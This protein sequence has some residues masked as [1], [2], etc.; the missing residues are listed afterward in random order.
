[1]SDGVAWKGSR[2]WG[3]GAPPTSSP[4]PPPRALPPLVCAVRRGQ[5]DLTRNVDT[6]KD[7]RDMEKR[8]LEVLKA[9]SS[10]LRMRR[11][12]SRKAPSQPWDLTIF[13]FPMTLL[14]SR[15]RESFRV[16]CSCW[17]RREE[18]G[19]GQRNV[20]NSPSAKPSHPAFS[21]CS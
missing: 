5:G 8:R 18:E 6:W 10:W 7:T 1:M 15:A 11:I 20:K 14:V 19:R 2:I 21:K 4:P 13:I 16:M 17:H 9:P 12:L 3:A